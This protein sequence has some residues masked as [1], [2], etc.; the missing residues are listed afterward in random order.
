VGLIVAPNLTPRILSAVAGL[1]TVAS[2]DFTEA[3]S[4]LFFFAITF[5]FAF[6][7]ECCSYTLSQGAIIRDYPSDQRA[8]EANNTTYAKKRKSTLISKLSMLK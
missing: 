3:P 2:P 5:A 8:S 7:F 1:R 6:L 4:S